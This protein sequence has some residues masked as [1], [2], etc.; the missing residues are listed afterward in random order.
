[1]DEL[2][3]VSISRRS[4]ASACQSD[5]SKPDLSVRRQASYNDPGGRGNDVY[6]EVPEE[7]VEVVVEVEVGQAS[8]GTTKP[9]LLGRT[10]LL[11]RGDMDG[12]LRTAGRSGQAGRG[13]LLLQPG[14]AAVL[15][16]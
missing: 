10:V 16:P 4:M 5:S 8:R 15:V 2:L 7:V 6:E 12:P 1:V 14:S 13:E 11:A 9:H 3:T